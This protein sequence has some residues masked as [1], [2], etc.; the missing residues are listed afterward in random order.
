MIIS[1]LIPQIDVYTR[2]VV[3]LLGVA[4]PILFQIVSRLDDKYSSTGIVA[5][6]DKEP[7]KRVFIY[8]LIASLIAIGIWS[9]Q[10][11][12]VIYIP[13]LQVLIDNSADILLAI[14]TT[15]L[16]VSFFFYVDKIL[17]YYTTIKFIRYSIKRHLKRTEDLKWFKALGDVFHHS[18]KKENTEIADTILSFFYDEFANVRRNQEAGPVIYP[19]VYYQVLYKATEEL[20]ALGNKRNFHLEYDIGSNILLLGGS[21]GVEISEETYSA[22]WENILVA[23][24]YKNDDLIVHH[25]E[26]A[27]NHYE[28]YLSS[29]AAIYEQG[30]TNQT[31]IEEQKKREDQRERFLEFHIALGALLLYSK[32]YDCLVRILFY[33]TSLPPQ[34][35]L[36]PEG[37]DRIFKYFVKFYNPYDADVRLISRRYRFPG[38]TG[39]DAEGLVKKWFIAYLSLIFLRQYSLPKLMSY[40]NH[41]G[42][43][44]LPRTQGEKRLWI[45]SLD[46]FLQLANENMNLS[47]LIN[48]LNLAFITPA[49][50][51]QRNI[52]Y[53]DDFVAELKR[54][55]EAAYQADETIQTVDEQKR[56]NFLTKS[57]SIMKERLKPYVALLSKPFS[58][59]FTS[60]VLKGIQSIHNKDGYTESPEVSYIGYDTDLAGHLSGEMIKEIGST[61]RSN[62]K[63]QFLFK[64]EDMFKAIDKLKLTDE[65]IMI[66]MGLFIEHYIEFNKIQNLSKNKYKNTDIY[67]FLLKFEPA[68]SIYILKKSDLPQ[69]IFNDTVKET[70]D[71]FHLSKISESLNLYGSII[72][73]NQASTQLREEFSGQYDQEQLKKFVLLSLILS[74]EVRWKK[75]AKVIQLTE[76]SEYL[77]LGLPNSTEDIKDFESL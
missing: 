63:K 41:T 37:M 68:N 58:G 9:L 2:I 33:T 42:L 30:T 18:I 12:P 22:M 54:Q 59:D 70:V 31:N 32:R 35:P 13:G 3:G 66:N 1:A 4:F 77:K 8:S 7:I 17:I 34:Y 10:L 45:S 48:G 57:A 62:R 56:S 46:Y 47:D 6:F 67:N 26:N 50:C 40:H 44:N 16:V 36:I 52:L 64:N 55:L 39:L 24:R 27:H 73:F 51:T 5:L 43:P 15:A 25:W 72:D 28:Y 61:F 29:I 23:I 69:I 19:Q 21:A 53:P 20:C 60:R 11:A 38:R 71:K 65:H 49:W 74:G 75:K 76:Y 14:T